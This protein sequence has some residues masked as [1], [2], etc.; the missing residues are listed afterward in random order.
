MQEEQEPY[1]DGSEWPDEGLD[2]QQKATKAARACEALQYYAR[3][4]GADR[5]DGFATV[6][7]DLLTDLGHFCDA[8]NLDL[9]ELEHCA[10]EHHSG[11][12]GQQPRL[13]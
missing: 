5:Q 7:T 1:V 11:E 4:I 13:P 9:D 2:A 3:L 10:W 12:S 8:Q 6:I